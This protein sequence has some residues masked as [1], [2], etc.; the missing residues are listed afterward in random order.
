MATGEVGTTASILCL[1][2]LQSRHQIL[3]L[4][5]VIYKKRFFLKKKY[6]HPFRQIELYMAVCV[7]SGPLVIRTL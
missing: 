6:C 7:N 4:M 2:K 5:K 3:K 1:K